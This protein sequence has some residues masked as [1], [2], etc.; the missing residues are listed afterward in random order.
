[1]RR[2]QTAAMADL[3]RSGVETRSSRVAEV[4]AEIEFSAAPNN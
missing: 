1:M 2:E 3:A 4:V